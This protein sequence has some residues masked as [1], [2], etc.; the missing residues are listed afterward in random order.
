MTNSTARVVCE[1][2]EIGPM[3]SNEVPIV[4][5]GGGL[6]GLALARALQHS[7]RACEVYERAPEIKAVGAG[8]LMQTAAMMALRRI[9][10]DAQVAAA[11]REVLLGRGTDMHG[12]LLQRFNMGELKDVTGVPTIAIHRAA[13]HKV[14]LDALEPGT[15]RTDHALERYEADKDGVTAVFANGHRARGTLLFGADGLRSR[16]REQLLGPSAIRYAGYTSWRGVARTRVDFLGDHEVCEMWG[17]GLRFGLVPVDAERTY[18]FAVANAPEGQRDDDAKTAVAE[19]FAAWPDGVRRLIAETP[20]ESVFRTDI[21]DRAPVARWS[22]GRVCLLG[23]AAHPTTPNLGQG[24]CMAIEDAVLLAH[25][26]GASS[27]HA[28]AFARFEALR[29]PYTSRIV[30]DSWNFGRLAHSES[31]ALLWLRDAML[32][33]TPA[34]VIR[35]QLLANARFVLDA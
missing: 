33:L 9:G 34:S 22:D 23:D 12:R 5:V 6:G 7:G 35:K 27:D 16:V 8:I 26:L 24:G 10:L 29:V 13:L 14:L 17:R 21:S 20:A 28:A 15:V 11:G 3:R 25:L 4:I 31:T 18:W 1:V 2:Y 32:K 19:R 30:R